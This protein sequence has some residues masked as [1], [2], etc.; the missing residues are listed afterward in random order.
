MLLEDDFRQLLKIKTE[1]KNLDY[2]ESLNWDTGSKDQKLEI[3]KDIL[4]MSNTQDG[5]RIIFGVRNIDYDPKGMSE[6]D[7]KSFDQTKVNDL[8]HNYTEPKHTCQVYKQEIDAKYFVVIDVSEF[9][10]V[11]IICK[12]DAHSSIKKSKQILKK[13]QIYIRTEKASSEAISSVDEMREFLGRALTKKGD[14][15]L[16]SIER[17]IKGKPIKPTEESEETYMEEIKEANEFFSENLGNE[18]KK[19]GYWEVIAYPTDYNSKRIQDKKQIKELIEKSETNRSGWNYPHT[20]R[21][22]NIS[23]ISKGV[24]SFT[25]WNEFIE[26]YRA[27]QSGLFAWK[28]VIQEDIEGYKSNGSPVLSF[29]RVIIIITEFFLF[30]KRYYEEIARESDLHLIITINGTK[31][32]KLFA[33]S[34]LYD[35]PDFDVFRCFSQENI[36]SIKNDIKF[37]DLKVTYKEIAIKIIKRIF[38]IFNWDDVSERFIEKWQ[39]KL[40]ERGF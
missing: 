21:A 13:G 32:R 12:N 23:N 16:H 1:S 38:E 9:P 24:Q 2:K 18:L 7:F 34:R 35:T 4:A 15:L 40:L 26:G 5:G 3:I 14:E 8:L 6:E 31:N 30:L 20:D 29:E 33:L 36:I 37:I 17:L 28:S 39:T 10:E 11:P 27:Y 22:G 25:I 19:Y